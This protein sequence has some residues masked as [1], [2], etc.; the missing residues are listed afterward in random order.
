MHWKLKLMHLATNVSTKYNEKIIPIKGGHLNSSLK[1]LKLLGSR[2]YGL[3][4]SHALLQR[5]LHLF[6][7]HKNLHSLALQ[8]IIHR[9]LVPC[10]M[11][12]RTS[13]VLYLCRSHAVFQ[14]PLI[15]FWTKRL[16]PFL[17]HLISSM[18]V[19]TISQGAHMSNK[20]QL[21]YDQICAF[22]NMTRAPKNQN[23]SHSVHTSL[24]THHVSCIT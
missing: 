10:A 1:L 13:V 5:H 4:F 17:H 15:S 3:L 20:C 19:L 14:G 12:K 18:L 16:I 11:I 9:L 2:C 22:P 24:S 8:P 23:L 7:I 21:G 6:Y